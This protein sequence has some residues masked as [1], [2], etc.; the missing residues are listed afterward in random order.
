MPSTDSKPLVLSGIQ[1]IAMAPNTNVAF[2]SQP[3]TSAFPFAEAT[4][5]N[6]NLLLAM[7]GEELTALPEE[8]LELRQHG[9]VCYHAGTEHLPNDTQMHSQL[10]W[11]VHE[12]T[13]AHA[14]Y[15][16][17]GSPTPLKCVGKLILLLEQR[18]IVY[19][20][21]NGTNAAG[22]SFACTTQTSPAGS[23]RTELKLIPAKCK[24]V[25]SNSMQSTSCRSSTTAL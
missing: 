6:S 25:C 8:L 16:E 14:A 23:T 15:L 11:K 10:V 24:S 2:A 5:A 1:A 13:T 12:I 4:I 3:V 22:E 9:C 17:A 19:Q 7:K 20:A 18:D 21:A